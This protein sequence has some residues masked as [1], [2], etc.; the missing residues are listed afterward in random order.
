MQFISSSHQVKI[1]L[2]HPPEKPQPPRPSEKA[3]KEQA[4]VPTPQSSPRKSVELP[5]R[6]TYSL[7]MPWGAPVR[8]PGKY[9]LLLHGVRLFR[10]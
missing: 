9:H 3:G 1:H 10:W 4:V 8:I 7:V 2:G 5:P 6:R